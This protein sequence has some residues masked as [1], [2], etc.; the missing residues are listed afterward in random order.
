[1]YKCMSLR[2]VLCVRD[3]CTIGKNLSVVMPDPE[4]PW[5]PKPSTVWQYWRLLLA[6]VYTYGMVHCLALVA[7]EW[8]LMRPL[9]KSAGWFR[10]MLAYIL[11]GIAGQIVALT[12]QP[13]IPHVGSTSGVA[14]MI[15]EAVVELGWAWN[16][17]E[18][19]RHELIKLGALLAVLLVL[20]VLPYVSLLGSLAGCVCGAACAFIFMTY[21]TFERRVRLQKAV[22]TAVAVVGLMGFY[23]VIMYTFIRLQPA[24]CQGCRSLE[25]LSLSED[26]CNHW[27]LLG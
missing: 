21:F 12:A 13:Y 15:G 17:L 27:D 19:P 22:L 8:V 5:L 18:N 24:P 7:L 9:E 16:L 2:Q 25:C 20:G 11:C 4:R 10:I 26:M 3:L 1:M 6:L 23:I 14:G